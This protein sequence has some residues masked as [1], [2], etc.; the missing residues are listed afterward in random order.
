MINEPKKTMEKH[1]RVRQQSWKH[2]YETPRIALL[3]VSGKSKSLLSRKALRARIPIMTSQPMMRGY[4]SAFS[5]LTPLSPQEQF[6]LLDPGRLLQ[7]VTGSGQNLSLTLLGRIK[8]YPDNGVR[9]P[10]F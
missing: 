7:L 6:I 3:D 10:L 1:R 4:Q 8:S 5:P 2:P 9:N